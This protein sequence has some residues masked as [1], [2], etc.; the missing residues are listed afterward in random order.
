LVPSGEKA[1]PHSLR[2]SVSVRAFLPLPERAI[3]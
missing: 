1:G 3:T 2:S